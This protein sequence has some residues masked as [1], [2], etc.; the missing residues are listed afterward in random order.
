MEYLGFV[1]MW[2]NKINGKSYI[3]LHVGRVDDGYIGSGTYFRNAVKK[4]G[5][6][7]FERQIL[8]FEMNDVKSLYQKEYELIMEYNAVRSKEFYNQ[9]SIS[10]NI[11]PFVNGKL[12]R[13]FSEEHKRNI[14]KTKT[15]KRDSEET[16]AKKRMSSGVRGKK[17]YNDGSKEYK[18]FPGTQPSHLIM[19]RL[20]GNAPNTAGRVWYNDGSVDKTF[21]IG[22]EPQGW[23]RGRINNVSREK[24]E[25][26]RFKKGSK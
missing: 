16:K 26:G 5:I 1:Y 22:S 11:M 15:G 9:T 18:F 12:I 13:E 8:Y 21:Y 2:R 14:A 24:D 3:G 20:P 10:P 23:K 19:G 7:N 25:K 4:Y 17:I 6:D